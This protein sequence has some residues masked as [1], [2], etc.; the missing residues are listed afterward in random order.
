MTPGEIKSRFRLR[1]EIASRG[2]EINRQGFC[3]C[4]FHSG[5]NTPS[6]KIYDDQNSWHCYGC[7]EGGDV[8]DFVMKI[9]GLSF[10]EA[11]KAISGENLSKSSR[12]R[13]N[14]AKLKRE[15]RTI[16]EKRKRAKINKLGAEICDL[17]SALDK[18]EPLSDEWATT[19]NKWQYLTYQHSELTG[20][21][22]E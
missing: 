1:D 18:A 20:I 8:I 3:Q 11:C 13:V 22:M 10:K 2:I 6:L 5:D 4:P 12:F 9:D 15:A 19:Y 7:G 14:Q 21:N 17:R 16:K